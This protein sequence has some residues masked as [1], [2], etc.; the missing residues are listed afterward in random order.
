MSDKV[1]LFYS[2]QDKNDLIIKERISEIFEKEKIDFQSFDIT[3]KYSLYGNIFTYES[4]F[5]SD[6]CE[7]GKTKSFFTPILQAGKLYLKSEEE[8]KEKI[9]FLKTKYGR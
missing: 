1:I 8:I 5:L 7:N 4:S 2:G 3:Q 9:P 6:H